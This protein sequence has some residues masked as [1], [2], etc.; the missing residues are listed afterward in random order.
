MFCTNFSKLEAVMLS[1]YIFK[2]LL[3]DFYLQTYLPAYGHSGS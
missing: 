2:D 1:D 3:T